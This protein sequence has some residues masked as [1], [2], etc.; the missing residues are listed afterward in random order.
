M[1]TDTLVITWRSRP[2]A[3][4]SVQGSEHY[5]MSKYD[6]EGGRAEVMQELRKESRK[7]YGPTRIFDV[8][9][10]RT[11]EDRK[12]EFFGALSSADQVLLKEA[13]AEPVTAF[14]RRIDEIRRLQK[15]AT[16]VF[17]SDAFMRLMLEKANESK[18]V[19]LLKEASLNGLNAGRYVLLASDVLAARGDRHEAASS[20]SGDPSFVPNPSKMKVPDLKDALAALGEDTS[21]KKAE[22]VARLKAAKAAKAS[23]GK[24]PAL[25]ASERD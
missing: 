20:S 24:R 21:G 17:C 2:T 4:R 11:Q 13:R 12:R 5:S 6:S 19:G 10:P 3:Q 23:G 22:L 16:Q 8:V 9:S 7:G 18:L 14:Q 15:E 25:A 1:L